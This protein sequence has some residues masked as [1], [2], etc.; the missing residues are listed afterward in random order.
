MQE[1]ASELLLTHLMGLHFLREVIPLY[2]DTQQAVKWIRIIVAFFVSFTLALLH[3][4]SDYTEF[5]SWRA[6]ITFL[7]HKI[8]CLLLTCCN[9]NCSYQFIVCFLLFLICFS[10]F[11][12]FEKMSDCRENRN[13]WNLILLNVLNLGICPVAFLSYF[14]KFIVIIQFTSLL[15]VYWSSQCVCASVWRMCPTW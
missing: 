3:D 12:N 10:L 8:L 7:I 15:S 1:E 14:I 9:N 4:P 11:L 6:K 13:W 2:P 5:P